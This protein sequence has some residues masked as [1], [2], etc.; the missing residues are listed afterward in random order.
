MRAKSYFYFWGKNCPQSFV[1][2]FSALLICSFYSKVFARD[3][4][5]EREREQEY[6]AF[7]LAV[8]SKYSLL[9]Q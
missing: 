3:G 1:L 6:N 9:V 5:K 7:S 4:E 8:M 2:R